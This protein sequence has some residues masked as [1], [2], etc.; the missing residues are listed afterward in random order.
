MNNPFAT[1]PK[2]LIDAIRQYLTSCGDVHPRN[3]SPAHF[4]CRLMQAGMKASPLDPKHKRKNKEGKKIV[5]EPAKI[6]LTFDLAKQSGIVVSFVEQMAKWNNGKHE[7]GGTDLRTEIRD[8]TYEFPS[9]VDAR[10]FI[11]ICKNINKM[12]IKSITKLED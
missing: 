12:R 11:E 6:T 9:R 8:D 5:R 3:I 2:D 7:G 4:A 10:R 1:P